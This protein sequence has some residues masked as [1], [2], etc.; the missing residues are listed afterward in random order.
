M[1]LLRESLI[2]KENAE[3]AFLNFLNKNKLLKPQKRKTLSFL[4]KKFGD[5]AKITEIT[6]DELNNLTNQDPQA[7]IDV[8]RETFTSEILTIVAVTQGEKINKKETITD[9]MRTIALIWEISSI[10]KLA[11]FLIAKRKPNLNK[12]TEKTAI[13]KYLK[14]FGLNKAENNKIRLIRNA[15]NHKFSV[16]AG[17]LVY[18]DGSNLVEITTTDISII[19]NKLERLSL[20]WRTFLLIQLLY[21]PKFGILMLYSIIDKLLKTKFNLADYVEGLKE[22]IPECLIKP[23][24][25]ISFKDKARKKAKRLK[26]RIKFKFN[27]L[28]KQNKEQKFIMNNAK[29]IFDRLSHHAKDISKEIK[30]ISNNLSDNNDKQN[31]NKISTLFDSIDKKL[32]I[33]SEQDIDKFTSMP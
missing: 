10:F 29:F 12:L 27:R 16:T 5:F 24:V 26:K 32:P 9:K 7:V 15:K 33:L 28:F 14:A 13:F 6:F 31:F 20:W 23:E 4:D 30:L 19:C 22:F 3:Q 21:N 17:K 18:T 25:N 8:I 1:R 11:A 2:N